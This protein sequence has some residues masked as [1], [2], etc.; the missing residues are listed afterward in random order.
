MTDTVGYGLR[1]LGRWVLPACFE[2]TY[3][4]TGG[5]RCTRKFI[6]LNRREVETNLYAGNIEKL[7]ARLRAIS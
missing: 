1:D 4:I 3:S 7:I 6:K 5:E 2:R